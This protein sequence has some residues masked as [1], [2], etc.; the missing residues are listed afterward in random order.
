MLKKP[1]SIPAFPCETGRHEFGSACGV[2]KYACAVVEVVDVRGGYGGE[3][4]VCTYSLVAYFAV[5][6]AD[7]TVRPPF[8]EGFEV[9]FFREAV[10]DRTRCEECPLVVCGEAARTVV[11]AVEFSKVDALVVV[12]ETAEEACGSP[13]VVFVAGSYKVAGVEVEGG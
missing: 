10:A 3:E 13:V 8:L 4:H 5:R 9:C 11:A 2:D 1:R 12:V 6:S 7:F